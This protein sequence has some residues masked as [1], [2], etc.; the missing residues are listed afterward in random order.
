MNIEEIKGILGRVRFVRMQ[1]QD[2][3]DELARLK[4]C[5]ESLSTPLSLAPV[6]TS[7]GSDKL[8]NAVI[9]YVAM[10][11]KLS[12]QTALLHD[13]E[14]RAVSLIN[15]LTNGA[16]KTL[17][18]KRY[19]RGKAWELIAVEMNY[20]WRHTI[21]LHGIALSELQRLTRDKS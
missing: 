7:A 2:N 17:L 13:V 8:S 15:L 18:I 20:S 1:I 11:D 6:H 3:E 12:E 14:Q 21:R 19:L 4:A 5:A 10:M 9:N 16:L